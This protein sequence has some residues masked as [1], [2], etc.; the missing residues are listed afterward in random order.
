MLYA[1]TVFKEMGSKRKRIY[2]V[3]IQARDHVHAFEQ[4]A[5]RLTP[6]RILEIRMI[7]NPG[8]EI[9]SKWPPIRKPARDGI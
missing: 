7:E 6:D 1:I 9:L 5:V 2:S 4:A 8:I 3:E